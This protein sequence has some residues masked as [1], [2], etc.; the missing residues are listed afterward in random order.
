MS[1][2]GAAIPGAGTTAVVVDDADTPAADG[3]APAAGGEVG[4]AAE[5]AGPEF[6]VMVGLAKL[7][8]DPSGKANGNS[9]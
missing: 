9:R 6:E 4:A 8:K 3:T 2:V 5:E 1:I 7:M